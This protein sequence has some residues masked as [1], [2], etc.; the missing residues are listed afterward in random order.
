MIG[1]EGTKMSK[2]LGNLVFVHKLTEA[3]HDP[4]AIRLGIYASHYRSDRDWSDDILA[5]A[6]KRLA[7]W[8][9]ALQTP[10]SLADAE[11]AVAKL[12]ERLSDDLDTAGAM[13][14]IDEWAQ[15]DSLDDAAAAELM[16]DS[17]EGL[18]GVRL[19]EK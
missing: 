15:A 2:S 5:V 17:V 13:E 1:L 3:G 16:A 19:R 4:A 9:E 18:L 6:E 14:A 12:R 11:A 7:V 8:R 10:G